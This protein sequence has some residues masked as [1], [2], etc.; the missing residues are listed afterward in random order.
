[1]SDDGG[2]IR[3]KH[4]IDFRKVVLCGVDANAFYFEHLSKEKSFTIMTYNIL[5]DFLGSQEKVYTYATKEAKD[6][7]YRK[8]FVSFVY[9]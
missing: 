3:R 5:A 1:M 9:S 4:P 2:C 8:Q 6:W 7:K